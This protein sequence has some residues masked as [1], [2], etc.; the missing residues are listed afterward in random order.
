MLSRQDKIALDCPG[1]AGE[2]GERVKI[3][4]QPRAPDGVGEINM[5]KPFRVCLLPVLLAFGIRTRRTM[6]DEKK[7]SA[8][9]RD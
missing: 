7:R 6:K 1:P 4:S 9:N 5:N 8:A 3:V 2:A